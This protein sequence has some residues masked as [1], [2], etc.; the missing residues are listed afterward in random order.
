VLFVAPLCIKGLRLVTAQLPEK[1]W[2][3]GPGL[4]VAGLYEVNLSEAD[5]SETTYLTQEEIGQAN[6]NKETKL[7][8]GLKR[9]AAWSR[10]EAQRS[11]RTGTRS[12]LATTLGR[13]K[14]GGAR[15]LSLPGEI[16][17]E[18]GP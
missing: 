13:D 3:I 11:N 2:P 5:L 4:N 12:R 10:S 16:L 6:G 7:P 18:V 8:E 1:S 15:S 17:E 9:P 14:E